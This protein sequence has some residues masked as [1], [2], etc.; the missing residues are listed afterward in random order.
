MKTRNHFLCAVMGALLLVIASC[1]YT[2]KYETINAGNQFSVSIPDWM[3]E[4]KKLKDGAVFQY[5]NHFRNFYV[6]GETISKSDL[7]RTTAELMND[8]LN[9]LKKSLTNGVVT[10]SVE[11][12]TPNLKGT[13]IE[14]YG[15]MGGENIYFSEALYEGNKNI[16]H[17]SV[18]TRSE[19]RKLHFKDD[20]SRIIGS[21]REIN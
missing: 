8:N 4:D 18:W 17:L 14:I 12:T 16:Y 6:I 9:V 7:K 20:I 21:V 1:K 3:K 15:K 11:V 2:N 19:D 5:A 10:D 13:R